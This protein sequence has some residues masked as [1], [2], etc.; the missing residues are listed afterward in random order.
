VKEATI[1]G[2]TIA[3]DSLVIL[4][5]VRGNADPALFGVDP[6]GFDPDRSVRPDIPRW[7]LSFGG[8]AHICPGRSVGGGFPAP[9]GASAGD[10]HV[11]GLVALMLQALVRRGI[12]PIP[13]R[14][15]ERD[16]RTERFTRWAHY[17]VRLGSPK[18]AAVAR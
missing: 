13:G 10:E 7:G 3:A 12:E 8:G 11:Y 16:T 9:D 17:W 14:S 18:G 5:V 4:D 15:P 6:E 2:R 1:A